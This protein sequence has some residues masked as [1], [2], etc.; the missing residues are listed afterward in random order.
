M[1]HLNSIELASIARS[2]GG[3]TVSGRRFDPIELS[4]IARSLTG[5]AVLH[6]TH[7]ERLSSIDMA[8]IA[9]SARS[10]AYVMF[11]AAEQ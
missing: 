2:G 7:C 4:S 3:L 1:N 10:P 8:S 5:S 11:S 6:I 9:R